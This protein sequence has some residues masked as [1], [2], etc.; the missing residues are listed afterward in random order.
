MFGTVGRS[1]I[2]VVTSFAHQEGKCVIGAGLLS[3]PRNRVLIPASLLQ[4]A[5]LKSAEGDHT[6]ITLPSCAPRKYGTTANMGT[7]QGKHNGLL[8]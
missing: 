1:S 4:P 3:S 8:C 2:I 5:N 6:E 7:T